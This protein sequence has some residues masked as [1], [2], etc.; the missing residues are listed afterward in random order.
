LSLTRVRTAR[1]CAQFD[2]LGE[3]TEGNLHLVQRL[4]RDGMVRVF[5]LNSREDILTVPVADL[6]AATQVRGVCGAGV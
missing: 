2:Y 4:S 5:G 3:T 1:R 6:A